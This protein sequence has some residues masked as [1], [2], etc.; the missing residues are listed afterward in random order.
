[1]EG[2]LQSINAEGSLAD[3]VTRTLENLKTK[4]WATTGY[5]AST[6]DSMTELIPRAPEQFQV[7]IN[8][9]EPLKNEKEQ[10]MLGSMNRSLSRRRLNSSEKQRRCRRHVSANYYRVRRP[11]LSR[12][13]LNSL[14]MVLSLSSRQWRSSCPN[15]SKFNDL[16]TS[17]AFS[18]LLSSVT[19]RDLSHA[20]KIS[21]HLC[22]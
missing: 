3:K 19:P 22:S 21:T 5:Q 9:S 4:D 16:V 18:A 2:R 15:S 10:V 13:R 1:M 8:E 7:H 6:L 12:T 20:G 14:L 11:A 17:F